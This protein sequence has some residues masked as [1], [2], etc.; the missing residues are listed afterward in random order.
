[1]LFAGL[2]ELLVISR[3][4]EALVAT[5]GGLRN[6][7]ENTAGRDFDETGVIGAGG[8]GTTLRKVGGNGNRR[9]SHLVGQ[10]ESF[11]VGKIAR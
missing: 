11:R 5:D 4:Q 2:I 7:F 6:N 9:A 8:A 1:L 3:R 10:A